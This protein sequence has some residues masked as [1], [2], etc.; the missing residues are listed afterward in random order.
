LQIVSYLGEGTNYFHATFR[1]DRM[2]DL[3]PCYVISYATKNK[4]HTD[5]SQNVK[6]VADRP[7]NAMQFEYE[8]RIGKFIA[9]GWAATDHATLYVA[10]RGSYCPV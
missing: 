1:T 2:P 5:L 3:L 6:T 10:C 8:T 4:V 7:P 9:S